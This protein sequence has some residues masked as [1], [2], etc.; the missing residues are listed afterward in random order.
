MIRIREDKLPDSWLG[1]DLNRDFFTDIQTED[2][3]PMGEAGEYHTYVYD[4]PLFSKKIEFS[5]GG[6]IQLETTKR[7][8]IESLYLKD[9]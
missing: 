4:G 9:K 1:Q 8:E 3:C 2:I 5:P 6:I 7:L